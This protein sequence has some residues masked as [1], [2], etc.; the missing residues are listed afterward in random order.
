V[1]DNHVKWMCSVSNGRRRK[2]TRI[3]IPNLVL[4]HCYFFAVPEMG[5]ILAK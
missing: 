2:M 4:H 3:H 5:L 1:V